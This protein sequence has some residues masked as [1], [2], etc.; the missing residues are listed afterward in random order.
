MNQ[1]EVNNNLSYLINE[2]KTF[3]DNPSYP[4]FHRDKKGNKDSPH[5]HSPIDEDESHDKRHLQNMTTN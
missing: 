4:Y 3:P 2:S 1:I 5:N